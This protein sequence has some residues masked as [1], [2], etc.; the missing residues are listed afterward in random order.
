MKKPIKIALIVLAVLAAVGGTVF[1]MMQPL[2]VRMTPVMARVAELTFTEQGVVT[3]ENSVLVF[4]V[5]QGEI[6]GVYVREGQSIR[7]GDIMLSVDDTVHHL[8]LEQVRSGIRS[9]EAQIA[10]VG[11]QDANMRRELRTARESLVGELNSIN[12]QAA[13]VER[14]SV[15]QADVRSEQLQVQ[16]R[17]IDQQQISLSHSQDELARAYDNLE[18]TQTL[19][20]NGVV[21]RAQYDSALAA[22][23]AARTQLEAAGAQLEAAQAQMSVIAAA[24]IPNGAEQF[25]G[26][27]E[28]IN[29]Q[30]VGI[31][32]QLAGDTTSAT[33]A[34]FQA[35]IAVEYANLAQIEREIENNLVT[36]P[37]DGIITTLH[38]QNTNFVSAASP[39]AEI[40][41]MGGQFIDVYVSTQD[42]SSINL[43][44]TVGITLRQR[45]NDI[46]FTGIIREIDTTAVVRFSA[47][48]VEERKVNVQIEPQIPVGVN[49]G[50]GYALDITFY[51]FRE[52]N[53]L[54][55]PRT[56]V[57]RVDGQDMVWA[58]RGTNEG[59]VF[60]V[61]VV[62]GM[63]LRTDVIIE[64]GL[65]EGDFVINDANN[66]DLSDG[67]RVTNER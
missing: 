10:N 43:G 1:Y 61:P 47:L 42:V 32:Q 18:R 8:R 22:V 45:L 54:L 41:V 66:P 14:A 11:V 62:L 21:P 6:N 7:A 38:A 52:E 36:A 44:D 27:R 37:V 63:E 16:Q 48:G 65:T 13:E 9:L 4:S 60:A 59:E 28:S 23:S 49:L 51:V 58:V 29:A 56:A 17:V 35:L 57:F 2:P 15:N 67:T 20:Q 64:S 39:V 5:A 24:D 3:A 55:V 46:E 26:R 25:I 50:I 30:I 34:H 19:Y 53:R 31:D 12:A 40:T 33:R